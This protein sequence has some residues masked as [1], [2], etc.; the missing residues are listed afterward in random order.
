MKR[1]VGLF[2]IIFLLTS[3]GGS[4]QIQSKTVID[5]L[6]NPVALTATPKKII[7]LSPSLTE[8]V[9]YL[10]LGKNLVGR[11][12]FCNYPPEVVKVETMG[13]ILNLKIERI[14]ELQPDLILA[15]R[16][17]PMEI[18]DKLKKTNLI[19]TAFDPKTVEEIFDVLDK[20]ADLCQVDRRSIQVREELAKLKADNTNGPLVYIEIWDNPFST[21]G[22]NTFGADLVR[23]VGGKNFGDT[24]IGDYPN[25]AA[26]AVIQSNPDI[27]IIPESYQPNQQDFAKRPGFE[28]VTAVVKSKVFAISDDLIMRPGPRIIESARI[29]K[30]FLGL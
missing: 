17:V 1:I 15:N 27:I 14:V 12:N 21:F 19:V 24:L 11:T 29:L 2:V 16:G 10:G 3:C 26:E 22:K 20:V 6:G 28:G 18:I 23:W 5:D 30:M 8:V 7:S 13:D 4:N 25:P 9:Y